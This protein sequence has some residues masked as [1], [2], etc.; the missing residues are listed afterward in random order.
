MDVGYVGLCTTVNPFVSATMWDILTNVWCNV[1][2]FV[3]S[4][5]NFVSL[6]RVLL[7]VYVRSSGMHCS[8]RLGIAAYLGMTVTYSCVIV[9]REFVVQP[10]CGQSPSGQLVPACCYVQLHVMNVVDGWM[11]ECRVHLRP[12]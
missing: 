1:A 12:C 2:G 3:G 9:E 8:Q 4:R 5:I 7:Q 10:A 6:W 11:P